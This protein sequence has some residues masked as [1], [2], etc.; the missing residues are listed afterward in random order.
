[1]SIE[2]GLLNDSALAESGGGGGG[3][4][5]YLRNHKLG[6]NDIYIA[7]ICKHDD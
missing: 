4:I 1:M 6:S 5:V 3:G 7:D 2:D